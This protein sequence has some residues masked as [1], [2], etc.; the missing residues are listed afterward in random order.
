MSIDVIKLLQG[1]DIVGR[2]FCRRHGADTN[3]TCSMG[4]MNRFI[5]PAILLSLVKDGHK[6]GYDL[7]QELN[8]WQ[9][10]DSFIDKAAVYRTLKSLEEDGMV[11][12]KWDIASSGPPRHMY[13]ITSDGR[14]LL[15]KWK[16]V[17]RSLGASL[18]E[19][20]D[21]IGE[22]EAGS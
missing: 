16:K 7:S 8:K 6:H 11:E 17:L 14:A 1:G 20:A 9:V 22:I 5:E 3:C 15:I 21:Q 12:S 19:M 13:S 18:M 4:N 2:G 10:T